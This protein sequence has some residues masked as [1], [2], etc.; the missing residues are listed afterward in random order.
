M[1]ANNTMPFQMKVTRTTGLAPMV[2]SLKLG[3]ADPKLARDFTFKP[4][5][6]VFLSVLGYGESVLTITSAVSDLPQIEVAIRSVGN[7][8]Q[9]LH[10]L[11]VGETVFV[12]GPFG[13][14]FDLAKMAGK[15][16]VIIAGGIGLAPLRSLIKTFEYEPKNVGELKILVGAKTPEDFIYKADLANW[17]KFAKVLLTVDTADK[18]WSDHQGLVT[19]L[20]KEANPGSEAIAVLCGPPVMFGPSIKELKLIGLKDEN[21]YLMLERRMK[22]GLG[23]C[24][25]CTCGEKYVCL[26]GPT[27]SWAELKNNWEAFL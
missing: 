16:V 18:G 20:L 24:Q 10:R 21:I 13:N 14:S 7:N 4:G 27:F 9:A 19:R 12:R 15:E 25:H 1:N 5:Q 2:K 6:F 11:K 3:F 8:T 17:Q 26:D 23:K 22:C